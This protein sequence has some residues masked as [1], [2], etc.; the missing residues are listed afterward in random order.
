M[1][2]CRRSSGALPRDVAV[3]GPANA[4]D[5]QVQLAGTYVPLDYP[6]RNESRVS[7]SRTTFR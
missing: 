4:S 5:N 1:V 7:S 6:K 2:D 3:F